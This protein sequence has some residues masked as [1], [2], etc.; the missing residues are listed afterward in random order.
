MSADPVDRTDLAEDR[1]YLAVERSFAAWLRT[2]LAATGV[3]I[4]FGALFRTLEPVW[5][6]RAAASA[7][8]VVAILVIA[9]AWRRSRAVAAKLETHQVKA[10]RAMPS[11]LL[12]I[13]VILVNLGLAA[14]VWVLRG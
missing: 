10:M 9:A 12:T 2:S 14:G 11:T 3:G 5:I 13:L 4:G 1:T 6:A 8:F 7:L